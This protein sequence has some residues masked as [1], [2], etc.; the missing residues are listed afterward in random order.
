MDAENQVALRYISNMS[1]KIVNI[2]NENDIRFEN[3]KI[4]RRYRTLLPGSRHM[5]HG[6][7]SS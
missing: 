3:D 7:E 6:A 5:E 2:A 1:A 4:F